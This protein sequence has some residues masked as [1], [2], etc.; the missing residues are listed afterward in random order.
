[1]KTIKKLLILCLA[2]LVGSC[3]VMVRSDINVSMLDRGGSVPIYLRSEGSVCE[4]D[5]Y[6]PYMEWVG[7]SEEGG[8]YYDSWKIYADIQTSKTGVDFSNPITLYYGDM[9][10]IIFVVG[11]KFMSIIPD[12]DVANISMEARIRNDTIVPKTIV[13]KGVWINEIPVSET[14]ASFILMPDSEVI[15]RLSDVGVA[16]AVGKGLAPTAVVYTKGEG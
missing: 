5:V 9:G 14:G 7:C 10:T 8:M 3:K 15:V 11:R 13:V 16:I 1:M 4:V 6:Q 2:C 12:N